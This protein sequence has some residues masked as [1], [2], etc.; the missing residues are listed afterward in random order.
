[1]TTLP[2]KS[3]RQHLAD[4]IETVFGADPG[5]LRL[6]TSLRAIIGAVATIGIAVTLFGGGMKTAPAF[7]AAFVVN[8]FG[9]LAVRDK[10]TSAKSITLVLVAV[11][12]AL[13]IGATGA[14]SA[15]RWLADGLVF[16]IC[17]GASA[18]RMAGPRAMAL[19]MVAFMGSFM[20]DLLHPA[21]AVLPEVLA[22][23]AIGASIVAILRF[24]IMRD[25]PTALLERVRRHLDRRISRIIKAVRELISRD[26][27]AGSSAVNE[28]DDSRIHRELGR[29]NDAFLVVQNELRAGQLSRHD[30]TD[31]SWDRFFAI[32]LAAERLARVARDHVDKAVNERACERLDQLDQALVNDRPL[33]RRSADSDGPLLRSIEALIG[34]LDRGNQPGSAEDTTTE[35]G[36]P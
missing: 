5:L 36:S 20:G 2:F 4:A 7:A 30:N 19:G 31:L 25:D 18:A 3:A 33:P 27:K 35:P 9:N 23:A 28:K 22:T 16:L 6:R 14:L 1:M 17:V 13:S 11:T 26:V 21:P 32:E 29:L 10:S 15:H 34:A 12:I 8:V 24:W